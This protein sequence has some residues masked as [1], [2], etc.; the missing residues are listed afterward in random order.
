M[1]NIYRKYINL[2]RYYK[3]VACD[4][5]ITKLLVL[6]YR[7]YG[8]II[9]KGVKFFG[10][11][12]FSIKNK[13]RLHIGDNCRFRS[14]SNSNPIGLHHSCMISVLNDEASIWIGDNCGFSGVSIIAE[15]CIEIGD[16]FLCGAN[17][18]IADTDFHRG[19]FR[20][21]QPKK[22]IIKD[23]VWLGM[24]SLILKGVTIGEN[25]LIGANSVV[26]KD[27]PP[28][29]IAAGIPCKVLKKL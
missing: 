22:I 9:G 24:N 29:V 27:I 13:G 28:N 10:I 7:S 6:H 15:K 4:G 26:T 2:L 25:S 20:S 16:N 23:N 18:T 12:R 17:V 3:D 21:G 8:I 11:A 1:M 5:L 19:D 14:R